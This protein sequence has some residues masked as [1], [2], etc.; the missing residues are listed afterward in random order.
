MTPAPAMEQALVADG[1]AY[2]CEKPAILPMAQSAI[3]WSAWRCLLWVT[4]EVRGG[5]SSEKAL[6]FTY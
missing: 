4:K 5:A 3:V 1:Q 6:N 2:L